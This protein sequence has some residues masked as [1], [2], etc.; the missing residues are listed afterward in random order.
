[1]NKRIKIYALVWLIIFVLFQIICF[2][3]PNEILGISKFGGAFWAGYIFIDIA[4]IGQLVCAYLALK[5]ENRQKLFYRL[6]MISVSYTG[7]ILM[8]IFG[9]LAMVVPG[10]P[11]WAGVIICA[12]ILGL[13][14]V[15][16]IKAG[17][18]SGVV[19]RIDDNIRAQT[20]F[21]K[22]LT[23]DA[24]GL[25]ARAKS[26]GVR[27]ACLKVYEAARYS[28]PMSNE[29]LANIESQITIRFSALNDAVTADNAQAVQTISEE[30]VILIDDRNRKCR[31]L[32]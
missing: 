22:S 25:V 32:K 2:A 7:L 10:V 15:A 20:F 30:I 28:D 31:L 24:E 4:F 23:S 27:A 26:E 13:S 29:A 17:A 9:G 19:E 3:T 16:V 8:I 18:A 6:P 5:E 12:V 21:I 11:V 14:A 1:M